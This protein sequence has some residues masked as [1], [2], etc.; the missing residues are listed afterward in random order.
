M[1]PPNKR[2]AKTRIHFKI[3]LVMNEKEQAPFL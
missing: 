2:G 3:I 1:P